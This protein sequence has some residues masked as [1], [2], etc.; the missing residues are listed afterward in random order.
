LIQ[1]IPLFC[2]IRPLQRPR[3]AKGRIIYQPVDNQKPLFFEIQN[4]RNIN[5]K[6]AIIVDSYINFEKPPKNKHK[7]P[8][9][10][11]WGDEDNLRKAIND[12]LVKYNVID[13]DKN[14][15]GGNNF[16]AFGDREDFNILRI[17]EVDGCELLA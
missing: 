13:D 16:K 5:I 2:K 15:V 3:S 8:V 12:A 17:Y 11:G 1:E 4:Y 10:L 9:S 6:G 7:Y 14:V